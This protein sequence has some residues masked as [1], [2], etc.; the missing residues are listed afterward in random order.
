MVDAAAIDPENPLEALKV[1][2]NELARYSPA[3]AEKNQLVVLNKMD[4]PEAEIN[5]VVFEKAF[6]PK[7]A[8][9]IS[10]ATGQGTKH[11]VHRIAQTLLNQ[12]KKDEL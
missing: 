10:A 4:L 7:S 12:D 5:A 2:N 1:I 6:L 11:L 3:L 9:P 8:L